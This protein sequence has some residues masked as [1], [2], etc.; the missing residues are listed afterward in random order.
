[1]DDLIE[2]CR[3][4]AARG[5]AADHAVAAA[6]SPSPP[7]LVPEVA[8][9]PHPN[10][11]RRVPPAWTR[12]ASWPPRAPIGWSWVPAD[13]SGR[14]PH[15]EGARGTFHGFGV[16]LD[17][18][19]GG[20]GSRPLEGSAGSRPEGR[21]DADRPL[22]LSLAVAACCSPYE[23][24]G[25]PVEGLGRGGTSR[26]RA[27]ESKPEKEIAAETGASGATAGDS[28]HASACRMLTAR[29]GDPGRAC[30]GLRRGRRRGWALLDA[31]ALKALD[32]DLTTTQALRPGPCGQALVRVRRAR[33]S[34]ARSPDAGRAHGVGDAAAACLRSCLR[35]RSCEGGPGRAA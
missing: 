1:M 7:L 5:Y 10:W 9:A 31:G 14:G 3:P 30:G 21:R 11:T 28:G 16:D 34:A 6:V 27:V 23:P 19:L 26:R 2:E 12:W 33:P 18:Q 22:P 20:Y 35:G 29:A 32:A 13:Q 25:R 17:V 15:P 4:A 8:G 24:V